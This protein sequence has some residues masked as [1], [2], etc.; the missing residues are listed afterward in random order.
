[1]EEIQTVEALRNAFPDLVAQIESAAREAG[2][3][4]ERNRIQQI[5]SVQAAIGDPNMVHNA[6]FGEKPMTLEQVAVAVLQAQ[7]AIGSTMLNNLHGDA[8]ASGAAAVTGAAAP[9]GEPNP[10][11]P[12]A[13]MAQ[14]KADVAAFQKNKEVR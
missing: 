8:T 5:E 1:M 11:S 9:A 3:S 7:A 10:D 14:A 2:V 13:I 6:K 4:A 12:E